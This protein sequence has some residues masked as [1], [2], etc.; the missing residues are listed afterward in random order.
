MTLDGTLIV[1]MIFCLAVALASLA[2]LKGWEAW[3]TLRRE[4]LSNGCA[5]RSGNEL[6]EMKR[7]V[8][9]LEAIAAGTE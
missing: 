6:A 8:R 3:L 7:R 9:K 5:P 1:T 4:Q 2:A